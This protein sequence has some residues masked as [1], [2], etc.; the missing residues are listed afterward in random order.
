[1]FRQ[2]FSI[3]PHNA[4]NDAVDDEAQKRLDLI[5]RKIDAVLVSVEST[6]RYFFWTMVITLLIVVLPAIGLFFA[7]PMFLGSYVGG[8]EGLM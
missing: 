5:E 8:L 2:V 6:R 1:M 3:L 4:Y 7:V